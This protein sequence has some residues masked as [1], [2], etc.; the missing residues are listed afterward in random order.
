MTLE[1][2]KPHR[3]LSLTT[4]LPETFRLDTNPRFRPHSRSRPE[5]AG[6]QPDLFFRIRLAKERDTE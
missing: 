6:C 4:K 5:M 3:Y 2:H 1:P